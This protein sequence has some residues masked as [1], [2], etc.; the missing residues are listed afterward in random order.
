MICR[1]GGCDHRRRRR[2]HE[3]GPDDGISHQPAIRSWWS[4]CRR[5]TSAWG[6]RPKTS[7]PSTGSAGRT[8]T[9]S[10][11][12]ATARRSEAQDGGRFARR[13]RPDPGHERDAGRDAIDGS[14]RRDEL[15]RR[16]NDGGGAGRTQAGVQ[17]GR[18][19]DG[20]QLLAAVRWGGGGRRDVGRAGQG[21]GAQP[22]GCASSD[23][24]SPGCRRSSWASGR[25][26]PIPKVLKRAGLKLDDIDL[27]RAERGLRL[28]K[29]GRDPRRWNWIRQG[30]TST[31]ARS[32][33]GIRSAAPAPS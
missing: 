5:R 10:P 9:S 11:A 2:K 18:D 17:A 8:W 24:A 6:R 26:P 7:P 14:L 19:G 25:S 28:A 3:H 13:D 21:A 16:E 12:I 27:D 31:A 20:R 32:P 22:L 4:R 30:S 33:W 29:P 1:R 23:L 15:V